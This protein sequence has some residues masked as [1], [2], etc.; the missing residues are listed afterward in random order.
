LRPTGTAWSAA[1][2]DAVARQLAA[3]PNARIVV[4]G[5]TNTR[6]SSEY[7]QSLSQ[8][9]AESVRAYLIAAGVDPNQFTAEGIGEARP[10][11]AAQ[12]AEA[13]SRNRRVELRT[14]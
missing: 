10:L 5:H 4:E 8:R 13:H 11:D 7:N 6:G 3:C 2:L 1:A 14:R 12:T 9:R